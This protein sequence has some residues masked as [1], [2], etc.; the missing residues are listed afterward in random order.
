M[1]K[2]P[3]FP[4]SKSYPGTCFAF[5]RPVLSG[6][7]CLEQLLRLPPPLMS[8][9]PL[10]L[11]RTPLPGP[12]CFLAAGRRTRPLGRRLLVS[13]EGPAVPVRACSGDGDLRRLVRLVPARPP[14]HMVPASPW[15]STSSSWGGVPAL[16]QQTVSQKNAEV[17][18]FSPILYFLCYS[19]ESKKKKKVKANK[20]PP[21]RNVAPGKWAA[22]VF[23]QWFF[24]K[25]VR[26]ESGEKF[27]AWMVNLHSFPEAAL[28]SLLLCS[29]YRK[30]K[31]CGQGKQ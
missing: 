4:G 22:P 24:L 12:S 2:C 20:T 1:R 30:I 28:F 31:K 27:L 23:M 14:R 5:N 29:N 15:I 26:I 18:S 11:R 19:V 25:N 3:P 6:F 9:A 13:H 8:L 21:Q 16:Y 7:F 10:I 17:N